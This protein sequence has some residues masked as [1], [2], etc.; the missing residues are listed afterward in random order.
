MSIAY[1]NGLIPKVPAIAS[2]KGLQFDGVNDYIDLPKTNLFPTRFPPNQA[3]SASVWFKTNSFTTVQRIIFVGDGVSV[4]YIDFGIGSDIN[5]NYISINVQNNP[6]RYIFAYGLL[7]NTLYHC[8]LTF[9]SGTNGGDIYIN[10]VVVAS[11]YHTQN[12]AGSTN[13]P[14]LAAIGS[15]GAGG[16]NFNGTIY[17]LKLF[18]KELTVSEVNELYVNKGQT[19]PTTA[20]ANCVVDYRFTEGVGYT[21]NDLSGNAYTGTLTNFSAGDVGLAAG[22]NKWD[23]YDLGGAKRQLI[24]I[25]TI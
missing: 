24:N 14:I 25:K 11:N 2:G 13:N 8:V 19:V 4:R 16:S 20:Q 12:W 3:M 10:N 15:N 22:T 18:D 5:G 23:N 6:Y 9:K 21:L 1:I 17:D 7:T